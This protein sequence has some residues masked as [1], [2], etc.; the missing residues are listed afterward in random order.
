MSMVGKHVRFDEI[1]LQ[2]L[3]EGS[4]HSV[5]VDHMQLAQFLS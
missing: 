4:V 1:G 5:Y 2:E 3:R